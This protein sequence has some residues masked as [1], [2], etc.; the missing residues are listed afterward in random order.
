MYFSGLLS[1]GEFSAL[2]RVFTAAPGN[3]AAW[4]WGGSG[5]AQLGAGGAAGQL[6]G[7]ARP[8]HCGPGENRGAFKDFSSKHF[9]P[10]ISLSGRAAAAG[11]QLPQDQ[12]TTQLDF[13]SAS[14]AKAALR[15]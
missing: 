3:L 11:R 13:L 15:Y 7:E 12:P 10:A 14:Q 6:S 1:R 2:I 9:C 4:G 8:S 5:K